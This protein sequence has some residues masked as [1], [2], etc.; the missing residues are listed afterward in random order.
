[1]T[2]RPG[3]QRALYTTL[4]IMLRNRGA[5]VAV[6]HEMVV[7]GIEVWPFPLTVRPSAIPVSATYDADLGHAP[8]EVVQLAQQIKPDAADRFKVRLF[9]SKPIYPWV[10]GFLYLFSVR[11]IVDQARTELPLGRFL[12]R[13]P[14]P[15]RILGYHG[16]RPE[17]RLAEL[18]AKA[19]KLE[20]IVAKDVIV[21]PEAQAVLNELI[22]KDP[23]AGPESVQLS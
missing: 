12:V 20:E 13:I 18:I 1:V 19:Q 23:N 11:L 3:E 15:M 16:V 17:P 21:Q 2:V 6:V 7:D 9:T 5:A 10:G 14:Q 8:T 4:E 22:R